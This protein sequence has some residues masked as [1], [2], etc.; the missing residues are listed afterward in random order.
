[1]TTPDGG[2]PQGHQL[3]PGYP[4]GYVPRPR[5]NGLAIASLVLGVVG[6]IIPAAIL[7]V[8]FGP[9]ARR[10]IRERGEA[11][12]GMAVAGLVLGIVWLSIQAFRVIVFGLIM[13]RDIFGGPLGV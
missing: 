12:D 10:Q 9:I 13:H 2:Q 11:G 5:T 6:V 4:P 7:A 8:I 3:P 1:V